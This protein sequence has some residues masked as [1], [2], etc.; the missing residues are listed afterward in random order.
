MFTRK[1]FFFLVDY[2]KCIMKN[3]PVSV[4][5]NDS[6]PEKN[7]GKLYDYWK[8]PLIRSCHCCTRSQRDD[9]LKPCL[10][11]CCATIDILVFGVRHLFQ[12]CAL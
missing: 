10:F 7:V 2:E 8:K 12:S 4:A 1:I 9:T 5:V 3:W 11:Q 6:V